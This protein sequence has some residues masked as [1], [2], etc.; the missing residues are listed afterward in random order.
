M[1]FN[2]KFNADSKTYV[3]SHDE[4]SFDEKFRGKS[5]LEPFVEKGFVLGKLKVSSSLKLIVNEV[6]V[7]ARI[8]A[9]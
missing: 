4:R 2:L 9:N 1:D 7:I 6:N 3:D 8:I 5:L